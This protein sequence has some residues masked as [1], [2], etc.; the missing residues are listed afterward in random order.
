[1]YSAPNI[2]PVVLSGESWNVM[3]LKFSI[4]NLRERLAKGLVDK[5]VLGTESQSF[6]LFEMATHPLKDPTVK[7]EVIFKV[8][9]TLLRGTTADPR[10]VVLCCMAYACNVVDNVLNKLEDHRQGMRCMIAPIHQLAPRT[11]NAKH[12]SH[13]TCVPVW[14]NDAY[15][16][17]EIAEEKLQRF[18]NSWPQ[19]AA[20]KD[21][22]NEILAALVS[23]FAAKDNSFFGL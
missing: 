15:V 4:K 20:D 3:K 8:R 10:R 11:G 9:D 1:V 21:P 2:V 22:N 17:V 12:S 16:P 13:Y 18:L 5:G 6:G 19:A 23:F 7:E 14:Q